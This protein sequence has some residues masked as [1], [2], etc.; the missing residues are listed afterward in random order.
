MKVKTS[1]QFKDVLKNFPK[2]YSN[3]ELCKHFASE[4]GKIVKRV[5]PNKCFSALATKFRN[6]Y[7]KKYSSSRNKCVGTNIGAAI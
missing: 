5:F 2:A 6:V 1:V 7:V 4:Y 3:A